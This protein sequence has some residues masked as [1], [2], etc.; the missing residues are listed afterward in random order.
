M[1]D[2]QSSEDNDNSTPP[3]KFCQGKSCEV[4]S[5]LAEL[6]VE[7]TNESFLSVSQ[8]S[9]SRRFTLSM[10]VGGKKLKSVFSW[11]LLP[12]Q[13]KA[14]FSRAAFNCV[15]KNVNL[16]QCFDF[17][18][19]NVLLRLAATARKKTWNEAEE[20]DASFDCY[21]T[22]ASPPVCFHTWEISMLLRKQTIWN[23]RQMTKLSD[24]LVSV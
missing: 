15:E 3:L 21:F 11:N 12:D 23:G 24:F 5:R 4:R 18:S 17:H 14:S 2:P 13:M 8:R 20:F 22:Q 6:S 1:T 19:K 16:R 9:S 7:W 10:A